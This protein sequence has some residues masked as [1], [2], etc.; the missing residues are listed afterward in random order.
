M[1]TIKNHFVDEI[2]D[3]MIKKFLGESIVCISLDQTI[4]PNHQA[5]YVD[6]LNTLSPS[7]LP[8]H[9]LVLKPNAP[10]ILL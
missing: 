8:P 4:D 2:D 7:G 1:L 10:I 6:F 5:E 3:L 9:R